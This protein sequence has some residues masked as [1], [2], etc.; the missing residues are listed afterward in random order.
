MSILNVNVVK[1]LSIIDFLSMITHFWISVPH[2][3]LGE[4]KPDELPTTHV[5]S[6][7]HLFK[8]YFCQRIL[9]SLIPHRLILYI[10]TE[11]L[12]VDLKGDVGPV[13]R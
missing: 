11:A 3:I 1:F 8:R 5:L 6:H 4:K 2:A 13:R 12:G 9:M 7:D 10:W